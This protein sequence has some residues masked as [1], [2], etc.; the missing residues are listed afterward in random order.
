LQI[1]S[2]LCQFAI[3]I[4]GDSLPDDVRGK[5]AILILDQLGVQVFASSLP[6]ADQVRAYVLSQGAP[7]ESTVVGDRRKL[8]AEWAAFSNATAGHGFEFDDYHTASLSHPGCV[9]VATALAVG[10]QLRSRG[11]DLLAAMAAGFETII[12]V[13]LA[14]M[15]SM[16]AERGFHETCALGVFGSAAAAGRLHHLDH[17]EMVSAL[18]IAGSHASGTLQY[19]QS[20]SGV[21]RLHAGLG[22]AG[23]I[24]AVDLAMRGLDGPAEILEGKRGFLRAFSSQDV[25]EA[26]TAGLGQHWNLLDTGIK[27]YSSCVLMHAAVNALQRMQRDNG[28]TAQ[29][30]REIVVGLPALAL[31]SVGTIG[32]HPQSIAG[33]QFSLEYS[34]ALALLMGGNGPTQYLAAERDGFRLPLIDEVAEKVRVERDQGAESVFPKSLRAQ[35]RV[36]LASGAALEGAAVT[37][38]SAEDPLPDQAVRRKFYDNVS[39]VLGAERAAAIEAAV[40]ELTEDGPADKITALLNKP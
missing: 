4:S 22:A 27:P 18:G 19:T 6:S 12:R 39:P 8:T 16:V 3:G 13:G 1:T 40:E 38:G 20:E 30:V 26:V 21:K 33:A 36:M 31:S 37:P 17:R 35:V 5:L 28:F 32:P 7:G 24:R 34:F 23:G 25:P 15:P 2:D 29:D 11:L 10:E 9:T 14:A